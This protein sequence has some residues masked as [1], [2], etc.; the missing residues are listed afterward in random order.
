MISGGVI[1]NTPELQYK[2]KSFKDAGLFNNLS[3]SYVNVVV[4]P[5]IYHQK[6][7]VGEGGYNGIIVSTARPFTAVTPTSQVYVSSTPSYVPTTLYQQIYT[8]PAQTAYTYQTVAKQAV[9]G[10]SYPKPAVQLQSSTPKPF[11]LQPAIVSSYYNLGPAKSQTVDQQ[12]AV[13]GYYNLENSNA[14]LAQQQNYAGYISTKPTIKFEEGPKV[15]TYVN[16]QNSNAAAGLQ[17]LEYGQIHVTPRPVAIQPEVVVSYSTPEPNAGYVYSKP[18]VKFEDTPVVNTYFNLQNSNEAAKSVQQTVVSY[19]TPKPET[20]YVYTKPSI[21]FEETP[22]I[23]TYFNLQNSNEATSGQQNLEYAQVHVTPQP[24]VGAAVNKPDTG[25]VYTKPSVKFEET[26][27]INTYLNLQNSNSGIKNQNLEITQVTPKPVEVV[28]FNTPKP[29]TGYVYTKQAPVVTSYFNLQ[30][31][32]TAAAHENLDYS[33]S[34]VT[35]KP[36]KVQ[37]ALVAYSTPKPNVG[38][39]YPTPVVKFEEEPVVS[40]YFNLQTSKATVGQQNLEYTYSKPAEVNTVTVQPTV[41]SYSTP[42]PNASY[43]F[44]KPEV[45]FEQTPVVSSYFNSENS[46]KNSDQQNYAGY[47]YNK[48]AQT[49]SYVTPQANVGYVYPKSERSQPV[50]SS[51]FNLQSSKTVGDNSKFEA[52]GYVYSKP[53]IKFEET[54]IVSQPAVVNSY[55]NLQSSKAAADYSK[56]EV[57]SYVYSQP[58]VKFDTPV[59]TYST[60][61]RPEISTGGYVYAKPAVK[62]EETPVQPAAVNSYF[63]LQTSKAMENQVKYSYESS[64]NSA[65]PAVVSS[66]YNIGTSTP[67]TIFLEE[68]PYQSPKISYTPS[69]T[70]KPVLAKQKP[71]VVTGYFNLYNSKAVA[72]QNQVKYES[73]YNY[74]TPTTAKP[75]VQQPVVVTSYYNIGSS[76]QKPIVVEQPELV[77]YESPKVSYLPSTTAKPLVVEQKPAIVTSYFN[78]HTSKSVEQKNQ[79]QYLNHAS[80]NYVAPTAVEPIVQQPTEL[81]YESPK[82]SYLPSSTAKPILVKQQ[83]ELVA[84]E[85]P[86]VSYLPSTTAK[87]VQVVEQ[88]PAIVTSYFNLQSSKSAEQQNQ[89]KYSYDINYNYVTP[90]TS[91]PAVIAYETPKVSYLPSTTAK[92]I[93]VQKQ[94]AVVTSYF[95]QQPSKGYQYPKP[96]VAFEEV[97][98]EPFVKKTAYFTGNYQENSRGSYDEYAQNYQQGG[99][100]VVENYQVPDYKTVKQVA[101]ERAQYQ[102]PQV[103]KLMRRSYHRKHY[104]LLN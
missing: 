55:F 93:L 92:P 35:A 23:N 57:G 4:S 38:Y 75:I 52:Q 20:G 83:P 62:F 7:T 101:L 81:A 58:A 11:S 102:Q 39:D 65:K 103:S 90:T 60:T 72:Q 14:A 100:V 104:K 80:Y 53:S 86:K 98:E 61:P 29:S 76:T 67:K 28:S 95:R 94:P 54:P 99:K 88:N 24:I 44:L 66:Y 27:V 69:T 84:Y 96:A 56:S 78:L 51:Y 74:V 46:Q 59:I 9:G 91:E 18:A 47:T 73:N 13:T 33:Q 2:V 71:A 1:A 17:N 10:Y 43:V 3:T 31:S 5:S 21:K 40:S 85:T 30:N 8:K 37:P 49:Y 6:N 87:P 50:V 97:Q 42:K 36:V 70:A 19:S 77:A 82:V 79:A 16:L 64:Y 26:P 25:Y 89:A 22:V 48:P 34:Y 12:L 45:K 41:V 68:Q 32:N 15:N 63:N